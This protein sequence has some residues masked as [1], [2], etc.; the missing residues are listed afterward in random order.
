MALVGLSYADGLVTCS[1]CRGKGWIMSDT[2]PEQQRPA[3]WPALR[4]ITNSY[5]NKISYRP[6]PS[7]AYPG[8]A[9]RTLSGRL[10]R[11]IQRNHMSEQEHTAADIA[12]NRTPRPL[13]SSSL[14]DG[15]QMYAWDA[16]TSSK[17]LQISHGST[18]QKLSSHPPHLPPDNVNGRI[19]Q[20]TKQ[21]KPSK[22]PKQRRM[23][24]PCTG[25]A[26]CQL[27]ATCPSRN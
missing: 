15:S 11:L 12:T 27:I 26:L 14:T 9:A 4:A 21:P 25:G 8:E 17:K 10:H 23:L 24:L 20:N 1:T 18:A 16:Q 19:A 5:T 2:T 6:I 22:L 13:N 7:L 3:S